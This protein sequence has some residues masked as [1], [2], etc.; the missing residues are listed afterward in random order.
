MELIYTNKNFVEQG[1]IKDFE[2]D[3]AYGKDEN[4]FEIKTPENEMEEGYYWFVKDTDYGGVVDEIEGTSSINEVTYRGRSFQ[5]II[6]SF[7]GWQLVSGQHLTV[8]DDTIELFGTPTEIASEIITQLG[9]SIIVAEPTAEEKYINETADR[10]LNV[11]QLF[12]YAFEKNAYKILLRW[13]TQIELQIA[14][15]LDYASDL[16]FDVSRY[17]V[18]VD[19]KNI[20]NHLVGVFKRDEEENIIKHLYADENGVI[21]PYYML[22]TNHESPLHD[23]EYERVQGTPVMT[24]LDERVEV[25]EGG[26]KI[27][28]YDVVTELTETNGNTE[29]ENG[30]P[31]NWN[32]RCYT[33]FYHIKRDDNGDAELN[34]KGE[35]QYVNY[36]VELEDVPFVVASYTY[37]GA[38]QKSVDWWNQNWM[39]CYKLVDDELHQLSS[40]DCTINTSY[41]P[42]Y[43]NAT[44]KEYFRQHYQN[45]YYLVS[46]PDNYAQIQGKT[47]YKW[48]PQITKGSYWTT[49]TGDFYFDWTRPK[50]KVDVYNAKGK[51]KKSLWVYKYAIDGTPT[52]A[53]YNLMSLKT[54]S[55]Y[56]QFKGGKISSTVKIYNTPSGEKSSGVDTPFIKVH[57]PVNAWS[58]RIS[59]N[60]YCSITGTKIKDVRD[61]KWKSGKYYLRVEDTPDPPDTLPYPI[62]DKVETISTTPPIDDGSGNP[63]IYYVKEDRD[64]PPFEQGQ[65]YCKVQDNYT[66]LVQTML[67]KYEDIKAKA[68]VIEPNVNT[69]IGEFD[70][71]DVIGSVHPFTNEPLSSKLTKKIVKGNSFKIDVSYEI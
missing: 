2:F 42:I 69:D 39:T 21:Q 17:T 32:E 62:Y 52:P 29:F 60:D 43:W 50:W 44:N 41:R 45:Y 37:E 48:D 7:T 68:T 5:G 9:I 12:R 34:D 31:K 18:K 8:K 24:G 58:G 27:E 26:S 47:R 64:K 10:S 16:Y 49:N 33:D 38:E 14:G 36:E 28:N 51:K 30:V 57:P 13:N 59:V 53:T 19:K 61:N 23:Y 11:Y 40:S 66:N 67:D 35:V 55:Q 22:D 15:A 20:P 54:L 71:G 46:D 70:V 25:I 6:A 1:V 3:L 65:T 63:N 4:D 56:S